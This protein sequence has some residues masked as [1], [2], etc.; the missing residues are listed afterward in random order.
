MLRLEFL[1]NQATGKTHIRLGEAC[2]EVDTE[3]DE[4]LVWHRNMTIELQPG[5]CAHTLPRRALADLNGGED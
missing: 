4:N 2:A 1:C 3:L 5:P